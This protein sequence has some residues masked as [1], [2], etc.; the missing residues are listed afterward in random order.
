MCLCI[1][2]VDRLL[3]IA[4]HS[5]IP[6]TQPSLPSVAF[7]SSQDGGVDT[8][9]ESSYDSKTISSKVRDRLLRIAWEDGWP[10]LA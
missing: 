6:H 2:V 9:Y 4:M 3:K 10:M 7:L 8:F 1:P 5:S